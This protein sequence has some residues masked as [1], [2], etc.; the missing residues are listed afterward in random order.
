MAA[1]TCTGSPV[2]SRPANQMRPPSHASRPEIWLIRVVLP[3]PLGPIMAWSSPGMTSSVTSSVT[4]R[5]P[6]RL[7]SFSRRSTGSATAKPLHKLVPPAK[8][9][10]A[11]K[12]NDQ[13]KEGS[14][15][16]LP[17]LGE[18]GEPFLQQQVS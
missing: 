18:P 12:E 1:R 15:D 10:A 2:T 14:E 5:P 11:R 17:V 7:R 16:H 4:R 6:N 3:A 9:S 8:E 13:D